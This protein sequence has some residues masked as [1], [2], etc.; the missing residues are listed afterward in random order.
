MSVHVVRAF[1]R[2]REM[3]AQN[4]EVARKLAQ[5]EQRLD[6][7]DETIAEIVRAIRQLMAPPLADTK[8]RRKIG[9]V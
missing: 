4:R 9:F 5:L 6:G 8:P 2:M 3:I 7:Q 1:V